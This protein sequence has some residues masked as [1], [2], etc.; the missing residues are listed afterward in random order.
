MK[1][2]YSPAYLYKRYC[3]LEIWLTMQY[4]WLNHNMFFLQLSLFWYVTSTVQNLVILNGP[5][6]T[7][8]QTIFAFD[9]RQNEYPLQNLLLQRNVYMLNMLD[10]SEALTAR[11]IY[12]SDCKFWWKSVF[13]EYK[14]SGLWTIS[15]ASSVLRQNIVSHNLFHH[16]FLRQYRAKYQ[17]CL[18]STKIFIEDSSMVTRR[19]NLHF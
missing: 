4:Y 15:I 8:L 9:F 12:C 7:L 18:M 14:I 3:A 5:P 11:N 19:C 13:N 16:F 10:V 2:L 6:L 17:N 1:F